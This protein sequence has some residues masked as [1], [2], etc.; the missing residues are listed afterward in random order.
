MSDS[1]GSSQSPSRTDLRS[2]SS[3]GNRLSQTMKNLNP[4]ARSRS[5]S[6]S[7]RRLREEFS[8][9]KSYSRDAS[10]SHNRSS[11]RTEISSPPLL[12]DSESD[13]G[14]TP[15]LPK[16]FSGMGEV[17]ASSFVDNQK[18]TD[19]ESRAERSLDR[20]QVMERELDQDA[21]SIIERDFNVGTGIL[22]T[23]SNHTDINE[24]PNQ[25]RVV[26]FYNSSDDHDDVTTEE[27]SEDVNRNRSGTDGGEKEKDSSTGSFNTI[28]TS[29]IEQQPSLGQRLKR[30]MSLFRKSDDPEADENYNEPE[31]VASK[32]TNDSSSS[33]GL[34]SRIVNFRSGIGGLIPGATKDQPTKQLDEENGQN[35]RDVQLE[36]MNT[37]NLQTEAKTLI[38]QHDIYNRIPSSTSLITDGDATLY[39]SKSSVNGSSSFLTPNPE[40]YLEQDLDSDQYYED[41]DVHSV[42]ARP[43]KFQAGVLSSLLKL[44]QNEAG[45]VSREALSG[46]TSG[47]VTPLSGTM[48]PSRMGHSLGPDVAKLTSKLK[49]I[50]RSKQTLTIPE[51]G[52]D[53][54]LDSDD[55]EGTLH[56][57]FSRSRN[58]AVSLPG[59]LKKN[60]RDSFSSKSKARAQSKNK[61]KDAKAEGVEGE[62]EINLPTFATTRAKN[63]ANRKKKASKYF[64]PPKKHEARAK[65]TVHI[66]DILQRQRFIL[67]MCKAFMLYGAPTH[68]LEEFLTMT[69]RVLEIDAQFLYLPGCMLVSFGDA[70]TRTSEMQL[71]K[72]SQG[73]NLGKLDEA[74]KIYK[75]VVHDII[76]VEEAS[77][78]IDELLSSN[79]PYPPWACVLIYGFSSAMVTPFAFGGRWLDMPVAFGIGLCVGVL[80]FYMAPRSNLY[81]SVFEVSASIVVS[82]L[83]RA[84][85][86]I[87]GGEYI[88]FAAVVQ[89]SLALI[90]PG[91]I[92]L[93]G[94]LELQ[95]R[96]LVAGA[97]RMFYAIIYSLFLGF[98][99]T[100]GAALYGW[101]DSNA[102]N[103]SVCPR[104][105]SPWYR[106]IFVPMFS[107]GL[108]LVNQAKPIQLPVMILISSAGY[109]CNYFAGLHFSQSTEFT[110]SIGAFVIGVLANLYSRVAKGMAV[111]SMLPGIF[112][113]VP[114]GIASQGS[115]LAGLQTANAIVSNSTTTD[116]QNTRPSMSFGI[117]MVQ[118][119]IGISV[120][121]FAAT[122]FVYPF[123]KKRTAIFSL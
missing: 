27:E 104:T 59:I 15:V 73:L 90:L 72:C 67:R 14:N 43:K 110:A 112:V 20:R 99:I 49:N 25:K 74:H 55:D 22:P 62:E 12:E 60:A 75:D 8:K 44:Y 1:V 80:Q 87:H 41:G 120:G 98:G 88:C 28:D 7:G 51:S 94:S 119:A 56:P 70:A 36:N 84:L 31:K 2:L 86:S 19:L 53:N 13:D 106:F 107:V 52:D 61:S 46:E 18:A 101:I 30:R 114:S 93:C 117:A 54:D 50:G 111:T 48:S 76:G 45:S 66:A 122:L 35:T 118:V 69:A 63:P 121:L 47:S 24:R 78:K 34:V 103:N 82:F 39:D 113:Q 109:A 79:N 77:F 116:E 68:R 4:K 10:F 64:K 115:L 16:F 83:G 23:L 95:S 26:Q 91:Y 38:D 11:S 40:M 102:T 21:S 32:V 89:G 123:G 81:S 57:K 85:G 108:A 6:P 100:L 105:L 3:R 97:V 9:N 42:I 37:R 33:N 96:S 92:I 5:Q 71:V 17:E 29:T 58:S 65:I